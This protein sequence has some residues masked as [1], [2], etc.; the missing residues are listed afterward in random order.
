MIAGLSALEL[1]F[2]ALVGGMTAAAGL[3]AVYVVLQQFRSPSR[4]PRS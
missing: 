3:F 2:I 4:R 1:W